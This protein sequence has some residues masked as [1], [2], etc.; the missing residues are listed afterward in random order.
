[1]TAFT[2][3]DLPASIDTVEKLVVW[4]E[5][6]LAFLNPK[7][8]AVEGTSAADAVTLRICQFNP[9]FISAVP[10]DAHWRSVARTSIRLNSNWQSGG[11][12]IWTHAAEI[13]TTVI[14]IEF[15]A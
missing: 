6:L 11:T 9:Y 4:G 7:I 2:R 1:M 5:N 14:P 15:K 10:E 3:A 13:S 12:K 8:T